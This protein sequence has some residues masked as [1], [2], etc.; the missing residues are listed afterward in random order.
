MYVKVISAI[1]QVRYCLF[2]QLCLTTFPFLFAF[3]LQDIQSEIKQRESDIAT[4]ESVRYY[5][6]WADN[7][8]RDSDDSEFML[9]FALMKQKVNER[10][11]EEEYDLRAAKSQKSIAGIRA[12][13]QKVDKQFGFDVDLWK[14]TF[15]ICSINQT[16][17]CMSCLIPL[18]LLWNSCA[19][20]IRYL[21]PELLIFE[22]L[23]Q[24]FSS[25]ILIIIVQVYWVYV[26]VAQLQ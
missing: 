1:K 19:Q 5:M 24:L 4:L 23:I 25:I 6:N 18:D 15:Q 21:N 17:I 16:D 8:V 10:I 26:F 9:N 14:S 13:L 11:E 7:T 20:F 22:L 3:C 12:V 2:I